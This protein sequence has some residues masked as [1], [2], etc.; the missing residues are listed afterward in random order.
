[1]EK[2]M[3]KSEM[4]AIGRDKEGVDQEVAEQPDRVAAAAAKSEILKFPETPDPE[5]IE[6][7]KRRRFS[8]KYKSRIL[9]EAD[10]C[11]ER[12]EIGALLRREGLYHS[13]LEKW[14]QQRSKGT[15]KALSAKKRG[16]KPV[17]PN[18]LE[19]EHKRV[20]REN[21]RLKEDLRKARLIIEM[22]KKMS[23]L[24]GLDEGT[25]LCSP[26]TMYRILDEKG[27]IKERRNQRRHPSY[28][29]PELL[30]QNPNEVWSWDITK[31]LGPAKWTYFYLFVILDIFSRYVVGWTLARRESGALAKQLIR[32]TCLKQNIKPGQLVIHADRGPSMKSGTVSQLYVQLGVCKSFNRPHVSNDN[33]FSESQFKTLKY[34]PK[35]PKRF[36]CYED[37]LAFCRSF[38]NWYNHEHRHSG[39]GF[40]TPEMVHYGL[41]DQILEQRW[42][43][44]LKAYSKNPERF[45]GK[46]PEPLKLPDS[47]W[48]NPPESQNEH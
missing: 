18:P 42:K 21:A 35:F 23:E 3:S 16:R 31:L 43:T 4:K 24:L 46:I 9:E 10:A 39:I 1:M 5:V 34:H 38:F 27:E 47:V 22:Q 25:Y 37:A 7:P 14:R 15:L 32:E 33:P 28:K 40:M 36:G 17:P 41:A 11:T 26:R 29:K 45:V 30:S 2:K 13:Y 19:K 48:I 8:G 20:K 44:L 6:R 12:G